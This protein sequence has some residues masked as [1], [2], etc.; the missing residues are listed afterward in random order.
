L[1]KLKHLLEYLAYVIIETLVAYSP[2]KLLTPFSKFL[3]WLG[4][5]VFKF[6]QEVALNNLKI[7]FPEKNKQERFAIAY[8]SFQHFMLLAMEFMKLSRWDVDKV[9]S[10]IEID[11]KGEIIDYFQNNKGGIVVSGHFGNWELA[12]AFM[13]KKYVSF[14]GI[15]TEQ[16]NKWINKKTVDLREKWGM[17]IIYKQGA[18]RESIKLLNQG[19][20]IAILGDQDGGR[21]G[22]F[23]PFFEKPASTPS[24]PALLKA[25]SKKPMV[26]AYCVRIAP[27]KYRGIVIPINYIEKQQLKPDL[28]NITALFTKELEKAIR[29]YPEQYLWMHRRWKTPYTKPSRG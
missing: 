24:G 13:S 11:E 17:K 21:K 25:K 12:I 22:L 3:A 10:M 19:L 6:R 27:F 28:L 18:V 9:E 15:Q 7:A 14:A 29:Q 8:K 26:F 23:I 4:Y 2:E 20:W 5:K 1:K 16:R